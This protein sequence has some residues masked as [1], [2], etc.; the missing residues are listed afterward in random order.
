MCT[1]A[2]K[3]ATCGELDLVPATRTSG[4]RRE[5]Y[6][7]WGGSAVQSEVDNATWVMYLAEMD[8]HCGLSSWSR[9][10]RIVRAESTTGP[11]GS[12]TFAAVVK[13]RFSHEPTVVGPTEKGWCTILLHTVCCRTHLRH[14]RRLAP[15]VCRGC[16]EQTNLCRRRLA[17]CNQ[18]DGF[19][20]DDAPLRPRFN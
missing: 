14:T 15:T 2:W 7:S 13:D 16:A 18:C 17:G 6:S 3:G 11:G 10:S 1:A 5:G 19:H 4:Y 8:L 12:Y 20:T 9:N